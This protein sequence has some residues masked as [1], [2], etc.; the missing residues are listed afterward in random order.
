MF[1]LRIPRHAC[2]PRDRARAGELWRLV[3]EAT[4]LDSAACGW[5]PSRYREVGTG[6]VVREMT[7]VHL[8]EAVYGE[9]LTGYSRVVESRRDL[10]MRREAGIEGVLHGSAEWVHIG[11]AGGPARASR[12][13]VDAFPVLPST[14]PIALPEWEERAP[15]GLPDLV[16]H[17]WWTEM[18][19][20]GHVNHPRY[21]DWADEA[22]SRWIAGR[23]G[24]PLGLVPVAERVRFRLPARATDT[25]VVRTT[26]V[27]R[28]PR[29]EG[30]AA[31]FHVHMQRDPPAPNGDDV[32]CEIWLVRAHLGSPDV[33]G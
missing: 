27:G 15:V 31:V 32:V 2:S 24:D 13:L 25:V 10:L 28:V 11:P 21:V 1:P 3:Q 19:P 16:V 5:P 9:A 20:M 8:R 7:G 6:W 26:L 23:G 14:R 4:V 18:D 33:L 22:L 12:A 17:P 29:A 30:D